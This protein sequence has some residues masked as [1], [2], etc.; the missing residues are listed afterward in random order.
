MLL[1]SLVMIENITY[2][3][4]YKGKIVH[5]NYVSRSHS[6]YIEHYDLKKTKTDGRIDGKI[7]VV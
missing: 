3:G 4:S 7:P 6:G 2:N 1:Q 5:N